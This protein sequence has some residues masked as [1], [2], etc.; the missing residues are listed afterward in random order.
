MHSTSVANVPPLTVTFLS[1]SNRLYSL[2]CATNLDSAPWTVIPGRSNVVGTGAV[3][4]L[5][6]TNTV[7]AIRFYR[8]RAALP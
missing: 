4:A 8:V 5:T 1:S 2:C 3:M 7:P 6:D